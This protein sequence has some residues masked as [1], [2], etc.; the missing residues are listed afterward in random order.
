M[1][2]DARVSG[3]LPDGKGQ[4]QRVLTDGAGRLLVSGGSGAAG[5][6]S[7]NV[8]SI[9]GVSGGTPV[10]GIL[11]NR[12][13]ISAGAA[14]YQAF[15]LELS[16]YA[17]PTD[18][19]SLLNPA[20]SGKTLYVRLFNI[21]I[22]STTATLLKFRFYKRT[23]P[24]TGG[25]PAALSIAKFNSNDAAAVGVPKAYTSAPVIV[26]NTTTLIG[27]QQVSTAGL[28]GAPGGA[29]LGSQ[30][31]TS[32]SPLADIMEPLLL[33]P[34]EELVLNM[35]GQAMPSGAAFTPIFTWA[36]F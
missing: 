20:A 18:L 30:L 32:G 28:T 36:E 13:G 22:Q 21:L 34:G 3:W 17:T 11:Q 19:F 33:L 23:S 8:Q 29:S 4:P 6:P 10:P 14:S 27:Y 12:Q 1:T 5:A 7:G 31:P 15:G 35:A 26:D 16:P 25:A 9:Q 24:N 2:M